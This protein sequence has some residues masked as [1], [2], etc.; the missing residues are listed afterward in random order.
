MELR[1]ILTVSLFHTFLTSLPSLS[2]PFLS[3]PPSSSLPLPLPLPLL[4]PFPFSHLP[5]L[6]LPLF[7]YSMCVSDKLHHRDTHHWVLT[8]HILL[9]VTILYFCLST[10]A[11]LSPRCSYVPAQQCSLPRIRFFYSSTAKQCNARV[12]W[13]CVDVGFATEEEC[14]T[15]CGVNLEGM[16]CMLVSHFCSISNEL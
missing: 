10:V 9:A 15:A 13:D 11:G 14:E 7:L 1:L 3:P 2:I 6:F 16:S 5:S 8:R 12:T 4:L